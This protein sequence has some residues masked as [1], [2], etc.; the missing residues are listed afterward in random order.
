LK[1]EILILP[2]LDGTAELLSEFCA[3][4]RECN[5]EARTVAYPASE[6]L[7]Y[8]ALEP[9]V[10]SQ[11]PRGR[12]FVLMA[13]SFSG[14]LALR[15]ARQPPEGLVGLVLSTSFARSPLP[16]LRPL[17][18]L[19]RLAPARLPMAVLSPLLLGR[20]ATPELEARLNSALASVSPA[21]LRARAVAALQVDESQSLSRIHVPALCLQATHDRLL[22]A[23]A[24]LELQ[25][26]LANCKVLRFEGPHLLLQTAAPACAR[27][28]AQFAF[29]LEN[30]GACP[31][32]DR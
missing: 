11:L 26:S 15:I 21:T 30:S 31:V 13:E 16:W 14:P 20:W 32:G 6:P 25:R 4:V 28:V 2:G 23:S 12:P 29:D 17:L 1:P 3:L 9:L 22:R 18:G 24:G 19:A 5:L 8:N 10:R 7:G 27:A